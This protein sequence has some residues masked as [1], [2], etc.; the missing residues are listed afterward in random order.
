MNI[1]FYLTVLFL[2]PI[3]I[4]FSQIKQIDSCKISYSPLFEEVIDFNDN[5]EIKEATKFLKTFLYNRDTTFL[6][7]NEGKDLE[8]FIY[9]ELFPIEANQLE[10]HILNLGI[11]KKGF[12]FSILIRQDLS[13]FDAYKNMI[14]V[15]GIYRAVIIKTQDGYKL[16]CSLQTEEFKIKKSKFGTYLYQENRTKKKEINLKIILS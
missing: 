9:D 14:Y 5:G 8:K 3:N 11:I 7:A 2:L 15:L 12:V 6:F 4:V 1:F 13:N 16:D 10:Y